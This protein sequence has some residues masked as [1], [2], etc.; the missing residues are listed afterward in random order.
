MLQIVYASRPSNYSAPSLLNILVT[1]RQFNTLHAITGALIYRDDIFLQL[2]EGDSVTVRNIMKRIQADDRHSEV[3]VLSERNIP[4]R[5][6]SNWTM[7]DDRLD[8]ERWDRASVRSKSFLQM[9]TTEILALF[10]RI[11]DKRLQAV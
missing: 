10:T 7:H 4:S 5:T 2:I 3:N 9:P 11:S 8:Q 1:S 6:F